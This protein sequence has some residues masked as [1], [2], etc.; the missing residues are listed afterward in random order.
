MGMCVVRA[1]G[2]RFD[3][4]SEVWILRGDFSSP[5]GFSRR[6]SHLGQESPPHCS[7]PA[8]IPPSGCQGAERCG[9]FGFG[10]REVFLPVPKASPRRSRCRAALLRAGVNARGDSGSRPNQPQEAAGSRP[11]RQR[12]A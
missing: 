2:P 5:S 10:V 12:N 6:W 9:W 7:A 3:R 1:A 11:S 4:G 8:L